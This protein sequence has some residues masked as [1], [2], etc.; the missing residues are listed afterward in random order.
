M[1]KKLLSRF[2]LEAS[3]DDADADLNDLLNQVDGDDDFPGDSPVSSTSD[4]TPPS[5]M[6][7]IYVGQKLRPL[8]TLRI[9]EKDSGEFFGGEAGKG[10]R[11][12]GKSGVAWQ[13][14]PRVGPKRH[15]QPSDEVT[16]KDIR[17]SYLI[18]TFPG[19]KQPFR[20]HA[21]MFISGMKDDYMANRPSRKAPEMQRQGMGMGMGMQAASV[22]VSSRERA[23]QLAQEMIRIAKSAVHDME[24]AELIEF[25]NAQI[26][27]LR[28]V[29]QMHK[30]NIA[31]AQI[32][33]DD[34][35]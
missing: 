10:V 20:V 12:R 1:S 16:V 26:E 7:E 11:A 4:Y 6:S 22:S 13:D 3:G 23:P 31:Y 14:G 32:D 5:S 25:S 35:D 29:I 15:I 33:F 30:R 21:N 9:I 27:L 17:G 34:E 2:I 18:C 8:R 24:S 28:K 19:I